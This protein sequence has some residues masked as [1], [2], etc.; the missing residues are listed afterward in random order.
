MK[1][2]RIKTKEAIEY[3]GGSGNGGVTR[4]ALYAG[5]RHSAI[6]Q[7]GEYIPGDRAYKLYVRTEGKIPAEVTDTNLAA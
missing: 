7:W 1:T 3:F 2:V 4:L 6:P 5:V